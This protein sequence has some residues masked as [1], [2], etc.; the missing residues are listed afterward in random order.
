MYGCYV[1]WHCAASNVSANASDRF[2]LGIVCPWECLS[3]TLPFSAILELMLR[4]VS[5]LASFALV[6]VY[7]RVDF[8]ATTPPRES[9]VVAI[10]TLQCSC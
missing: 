5:G 1:Y 6:H 9:S 7:R 3:A 10:T 4:I 2:R 8:M